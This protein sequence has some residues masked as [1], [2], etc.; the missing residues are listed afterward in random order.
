MSL[1]IDKDKH[2][3]LFNNNG[4]N[5]KKTIECIN[6]GYNLLYGNNDT[7]DELVEQQK[8]NKTKQEI[9]EKINV[10]N[11]LT[12]SRL[13]NLETLLS[14]LNLNDKMNNLD[15][16]VNKLFGISNNSSK[17]GEVSEDVIYDF[18]KENFKDYSY[19]KKSHIAHSGDGELISPSS[20]KCLVEIK[21]YT[22]S[23]TSKEINK[24]V[25]D[26]AYTG[27]TFGL[28]ISLQSNIATKKGIQFD[29]Y[30]KEGIK[31]YCVFVSNT[32][33]E[34]SRVESAIYILENV[35]KF[36]KHFESD[37][38]LLAVISN[39]INCN[40]S[41]LNE[42][43]EQ[44]STMKHKYLDMENNIKKQLDLYYYNI[45]DT[46]IKVKNKIDYITNNTISDF[47]EI[48]NS[49]TCKDQWDTISEQIP[50]KVKPLFHKLT[51]VFSKKGFLPNKENRIIEL[52]KDEQKICELKL[53]KDK[54]L[55]H[56]NSITI[57][58]NKKN[59][60][61]SIKYIEIILD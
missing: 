6:I 45:R 10:D 19:D 8:L 52:Y 13:E 22:N 48:E 7:P 57:E 17:R 1:K 39:K 37:Q 23:V 20:L 25:Y 26:M 56:N 61:D 2:P 46:E 28:F 47:K 3:M 42:I 34:L 18:F 33:D 51:N 54:V 38:D 15:E 58:V 27:N 14:S 60:D 16:I 11:Q 55:V 24:F 35:F 31:R 32:F 4:L 50:D 43:V 49:S 29:V 36:Q 53:M 40:L 12:C 9:I 41:E 44:L 5:K 21:N 59:V 30:I